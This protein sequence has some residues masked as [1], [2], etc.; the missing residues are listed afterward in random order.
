M[1]ECIVCGQI[2]LDFYEKVTYQVRE[3]ELPYIRNPMCS[4]CFKDCD[5]S[6]LESLD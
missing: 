5:C 6:G 2:I 4:E 1:V 3:N